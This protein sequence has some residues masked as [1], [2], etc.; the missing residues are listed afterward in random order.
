MTPER[1]PLKVS[2]SAPAIVTF[3]VMLSTAPPSGGVAPAADRFSNNQDP[4]GASFTSPISA[5]RSWESAGSDEAASSSD[6]ASAL[7]PSP[8]RQS[9]ISCFRF[10]IM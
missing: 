2:P 9:A 5:M 6:A 10:R 3:P 1:L 7:A 4:A 8:R